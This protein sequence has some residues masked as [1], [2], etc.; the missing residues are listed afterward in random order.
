MGRLMSATLVLVV[1][2]AFISTVAGLSLTSNRC[3]FDDLP[4]SL[5]TN[6]SSLSYLGFNNEFHIHG[7]FYSNF[8]NH[9]HNTYFTLTEL[10]YFRI[11]VA[12]QEDWDV[13]LFLLNQDTKQM[14][15]SAIA[16]YGEELI[17][18]SL[19]PGNYRLRWNVLSTFFVFVF[20]FFLKKTI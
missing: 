10:S 2:A 15:A 7:E 18:V 11:S 17:T 14:V 16:F 4:E 9:E 1:T 3:S 19:P 13:D 5:P 6:L 12:P 8:T 20:N